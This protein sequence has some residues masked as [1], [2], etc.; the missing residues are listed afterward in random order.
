MSTNSMRLPS[1]DN[2]DP[3]ET[4]PRNFD[5]E[6]PTPTA[7][8]QMISNHGSLRD[9]EIEIEMN[10]CVLAFEDGHREAVDY[11]NEFLA[12]VKR[13]INHGFSMH[14]DSPVKGPLWKNPLDSG[15]HLPKVHP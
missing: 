12:N 1:L 2:F 13:I 11:D 3:S 10:A 14:P 5:L 8:C 4:S 7:L 9:Y 15:M 6:V